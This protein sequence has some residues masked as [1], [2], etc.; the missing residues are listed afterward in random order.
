MQASHPLLA[1]V[2]VTVTLESREFCSEFPPFHSFLEPD[3]GQYVVTE[4]V[5]G[6]TGVALGSCSFFSIN[7]PFSMYFD[8]HSTEL[9][10]IHVKICSF[11]GFMHFGPMNRK[12]C[13]FRHF[14]QTA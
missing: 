9:K 13:I 7:S 6:T 11:A 10:T 2:R 5:L 12:I 14:M 8:R 1:S 4:L 3:D